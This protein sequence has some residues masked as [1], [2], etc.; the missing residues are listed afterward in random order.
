M[1]P[2]PG[3]FTGVC[4]VIAVGLSLGAGL[5]YGTDSAIEWAALLAVAALC[6]AALPP[7]RIVAAAAGVVGVIAGLWAA[8]LLHRG[9]PFD[10]SAI[11]QARG[12]ASLALLSA[13]LLVAALLRALWS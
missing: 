3:W 1:K 2:V 7:R 4:W 9:A 6:T 11:A 5:Q 13:W 10:T 8:S 12:T